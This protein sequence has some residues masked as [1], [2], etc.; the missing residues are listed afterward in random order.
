MKEQLSNPLL[1]I[2]A[3]FGSTICFIT[4]LS[5]I[6]FSVQYII[7]SFFLA[8]IPFMLLVLYLERKYPIVHMPPVTFNDIIG[9]FYDTAF[10]GLLIGPISISII[11]NLLQFIHNKD[12]IFDINGIILNLILTDLG[13]YIIHR[14]LYHA[15]IYDGF[16]YYFYHIHNP[17]HLVKYLDFLRGN[18]STLLDNGVLGFQL[19]GAVS[20]Y[21]LGLNL[22][23]IMFSYLIIILLQIVHHANFTF[24]IGPLRYIFVD[25][26]VHKIHHC[27]GGNKVNFAGVF[28]FLD[29]LFG[30]YY[31]NH[32]L[33][34]NE[35]HF[36]NNP[37]LR[38]F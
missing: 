22:E 23:S 7:L 26:H 14:N 35:L 13:Y 9:A 8:G 5:F 2:F 29:L 38:W 33:C 16:M 31:E 11:W 24:N 17:H 1:G 27:I 21:L 6:H 4:L 37:Y 20:G 3:H 28:S 15:N 32:N 30:T 12:A 36:N 18:H 10:Y 25:S 19:C 34:A